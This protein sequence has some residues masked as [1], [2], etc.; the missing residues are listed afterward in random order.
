MKSAT[1]LSLVVLIA[2]QSAFARLGDS[3]SSAES[4]RQALHGIRKVNLRTGYK[5]HEITTDANVIREFVSPSGAIFAVAWNGLSHPDLTQL[6]GTYYAEYVE[7]ERATPKPKGR[8]ELTVTSQNMKSARFGHMRA[9]HGKAWI[10]ALVPSG[11]D[12]SLIQ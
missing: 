9:V 11:F 7:A 6:F 3:E 2:S 8:A 5:I 1:L 10:P 12:L 4:D